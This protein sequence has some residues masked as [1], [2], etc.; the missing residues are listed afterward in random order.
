LNKKNSFVKNN[1]L[2]I[3]INAVLNFFGTVSGTLINLLNIVHS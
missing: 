1:L 3:K 2:E